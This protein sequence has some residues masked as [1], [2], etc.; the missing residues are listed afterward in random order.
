LNS[1]LVAVLVLVLEKA[2]YDDENKDEKSLS[3]VA[4][5]RHERLL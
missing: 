4:V 3:F 5:Q 2:E 1:V